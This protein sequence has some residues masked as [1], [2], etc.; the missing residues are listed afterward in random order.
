MNSIRYSRARRS[1]SSDINMAPLIDMIFIL[2]IFFLVTTSFTKESGVDVDRPVAASAQTKE[3]AN[4]I[5]GI[6]KDGLVHIENRVVDVRSVRAVME[7]F[8]AEVPEGSVVIAADKASVT[9]VVIAVL[10]ACR[11]AGVKHVSVAARKPS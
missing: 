1:G 6:D 3:Q 4:V 10:D 9:G 11:M 5:I 8:L 2:L 7:R